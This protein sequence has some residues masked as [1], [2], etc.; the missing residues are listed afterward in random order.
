MQFYYSYFLLHKLLG[1]EYIG[2]II[3]ARTILLS[4]ATHYFYP[5]NLVSLVVSFQRFVGQPVA[6]SYSRFITQLEFSN[7]RTIDAF[8]IKHT[9]GREN[10]KY[11][12]VLF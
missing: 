12:P 4:S 2:A 5:H 10:M 6:L 7:D 9:N 8:L 3:L 11:F 1:D